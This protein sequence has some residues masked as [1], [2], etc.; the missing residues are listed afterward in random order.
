MSK[1]DDFEIVDDSRESDSLSDS[2]TSELNTSDKLD[3]IKSKINSI[4]TSNSK[5]DL[6]YEL[7]REIYSSHV[8]ISHKEFSRV[9]KEFLQMY[10]SLNNP[11]NSHDVA[12]CACIT[13]KNNC[14]K[15]I[16]L[17]NTLINS[18]IN[19]WID[20]HKLNRMTRIIL[21]SSIPP[22]IYVIFNVSK[23]GRPCCTIL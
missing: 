11:D 1:G 14:P 6:N 2:S 7:Y 5:N 18:I 4:I 22:A 15:S 8:L 12:I 9:Y 16:N 20:D 23:P 21:E 13:V 3:I 10:N 19:K 17:R